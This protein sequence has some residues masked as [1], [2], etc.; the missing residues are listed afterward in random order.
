[1]ANQTAPLFPELGAFFAEAR[2]ESELIPAQRK[3]DLDQLAL[4]IKERRRAGKIAQ[5]VFICTHNSRRSHLAQIWAQTAAHA[6][7]L[8]G[9]ETYSGGTEATAFNA[10]AVAAIER[11]GFRVETATAGDN[12]LITVRC[13]PEVPPMECFSKVYDQAPNPDR[14]FCAVMTCSAADE[15]CPIVFGAAER[16]V[17]RYDDPKAFDGTPE[18]TQQYDQ[19]CR[20]I[21]REMVWGLGRARN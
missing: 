20:Q 4:F 15:H 7:G 3:A 10:R 6:F 21:A 11:A 17:I 14:D 5:L 1:M 18:E 8:N 12:P 16:I 19:R 13:A 9:I 2:S